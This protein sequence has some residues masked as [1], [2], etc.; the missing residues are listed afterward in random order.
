MVNEY[1]NGKGVEESW[2][3][4]YWRVHGGSE[5]NTR[6]ESNSYFQKAEIHNKVL[7]VTLEG[8]MNHGILR[9]L[10]DYKVDLTFLL[11]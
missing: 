5:K 9:P 7:T 11:E 3:G 6:I 10:G 1:W 4:L 2:K 8:V